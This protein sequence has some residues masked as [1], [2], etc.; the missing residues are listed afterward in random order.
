MEVQLY[1]FF[2]LGDR[3]GW[4]VQRQAPGKTAGTHYTADWVGLGADVDRYG[5]C[6]PHWG[7]NRPS[8]QPVVSRYTDCAIPVPSSLWYTTLNLYVL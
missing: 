4:V 6:R 7:S 2:N 5:K 3:K 8:V 1:P